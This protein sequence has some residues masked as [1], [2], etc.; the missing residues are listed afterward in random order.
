MRTNDVNKPVRLNRIPGVVAILA[1]LLALAF[2]AW[3][4]ELWRVQEFLQTR[5]QQQTA[6]LDRELRLL[7]ILPR[8]LSLDP[9][10]ANA[11]TQTDSPSSAIQIANEALATAKVQ[12]GVAFTFLMNTDGDTVASSNWNDPVSFVG[13]NYKFRPYFSGALQGRRTT[14]FAVGATTGVP[15]YFIAESVRAGGAIVGVIVVKLELDQL[16]QSL[17]DNSFTSLLTDELGVVILS[18]EPA[19]LYAPTKTISDTLQQTIASD[20]RYLLNTQSTLTPLPD[21][22]W[23]RQAWQW[24]NED[25]TTRYVVINGKLASENWTLSNFVPYTAI[26]KGAALYFAILASLLAIALLIVRSYRQRRL[27]ALTRERHAALLESEVRQRTSE[28]QS[29]Q[30]ELIAQ[31]NFA[32]L[33]RMSAAIN[34]EINQPLA[35]LRFNLAALRQMIDKPDTADNDLRETIIA[36]D[37]TTK[38][39]GRVVE[40]LRSVARQGNSD[41]SQVSVNHLILEVSNIVRRERPTAASA[42]TVANDSAIAATYVWGNEVLIQQALLNLLYNA[43]DAVLDTKNASVQLNSGILAGGEHRDTVAIGVLDNGDGIDPALVEHLFQPFQSELTHRKGLGLGLTLAK[44]IVEDH[45][46]NLSYEP[47]ALGGSHFSIQLPIHHNA[48]SEPVR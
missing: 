7:S 33:G 46:G 17:G 36:S 43:L 26:A 37:R 41:M 20:R 25:H 4:V 38:R 24:Q 44:Q 28:L 3:L 42:L 39:I 11:L 34:H 10:M 16:L 30:Q 47:T 29:A 2:I 23:S 21:T 22:L 5:A 18:T 19:L 13:R 27:I 31:S 35:S 45:N 14:F 8:L 12:S 40:T 9:R 15:G 6:E 1:T 48:Q 32:M